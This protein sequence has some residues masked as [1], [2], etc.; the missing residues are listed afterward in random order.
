MSDASPPPDVNAGVPW[1][2]YAVF[3]A[4]TCAGLAADLV[5]KAWVFSWPT[6]LGEIYWIVPGYFGF[7]SS[8]NEGALFGMGQGQVGVFAAISIVAAIAI[9][10]WL[11]VWRA[12]RDW[13]LAITLGLVMGGVLGNLYDRLGLPGLRWAYPE[14]RIGEPVY[15]VRDWILIQAS[16]AW[17]WPNFNIADSLLVAGAIL[18]FLRAWCEPSESKESDDTDADPRPA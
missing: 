13:W 4:L 10:V 18:L 7:Q 15:A 14:E 16:D 6:P 3:L 5:T 12:A 17:R 8:L 2:R 9:P 1:S 11:F